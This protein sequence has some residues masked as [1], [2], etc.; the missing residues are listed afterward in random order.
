MRFSAS[1]FFAFITAIFVAAN[2]LVRHQDTEDNPAPLS[3]LDCD[4]S[5]DAP[6]AC[7]PTSTCCTAGPDFVCRQVKVCTL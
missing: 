6:F 5:D 1:V 4:F 7:P 2:P 3:L